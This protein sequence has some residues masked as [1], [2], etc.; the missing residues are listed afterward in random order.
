MATYT[1]LPSGRWRVQVRRAGAYRA[2]TFD[3]KTEAEDWAAGVEGRAG[4]IAAP[5]YKPAQATQTLAGLVADYLASGARPGKS[6]AATL[7]RLAA[8]PLGRSRLNALSAAALRRFVERRAAGGAGGVTIAGDLSVLSTLLKWGRHAQHL[9]LPVEL[10]LAA[11]RDL[12]DRGLATRGAA[13]EREPSDAEL[14]R[15]YRHWE[16]NGRQRIPMA[17]LCRFALASAL[18]QEE[19][20]DLRAEDVDAAARSVIVRTRRDAGDAVVPLLPPAWAIVAPLIRQRSEGR[21][22]PYPPASVSTAFTRGCA[23]LGIADLRFQDLR[24]RAIADLFRQ[25][26]DI[27]RVALL[28]GHRH[29]AALRRYAQVRPEDVHAAYAKAS[30]ARLVPLRQRNRGA[31]QEPARL[32]T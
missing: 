10:A 14:E 16:G 25:G 5:G 2:A 15:L 12:P 9:D 32:R 19:I 20:C 21:L 7:E 17:T 11:R 23:A 6:S 30:G 24:H 28:S 8:D 31:R 18:R 1:R 29:W 22:F 3:V 27:A 4:R 13:R 26:L